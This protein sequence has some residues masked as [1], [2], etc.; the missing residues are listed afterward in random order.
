[1]ETE[2]ALKTYVSS[3]GI[4]KTV[5]ERLEK[6]NGS[7]ISELLAENNGLLDF[8]MVEF[9]AKQNDPFIVE[10]FCEVGRLLGQFLV[11]IVNILNPNIIV[12][13]GQVINAYP[14]MLRQIEDVLQEQVF[15]KQSQ[16]DK[17]FNFSCPQR[18]G[19]TWSCKLGLS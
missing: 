2:D 11:S 4:I 3:Q 17:G 19:K 16:K 6:N 18:K 13:G 9:A 7:L 1:M 8:E 15:S 5:R 12:L 14:S 10:I